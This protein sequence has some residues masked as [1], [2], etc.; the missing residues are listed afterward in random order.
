VSCVCS[1]PDLQFVTCPI[2]VQLKNERAMQR[3]KQ[4]E[5]FSIEYE[6]RNATNQII[7]AQ[8]SLVSEHTEFLVAGELQSQIQLMPAVSEDDCYTLRYTLFP[9]K[10]GRLFLPKLRIGDRNTAKVNQVWLIKDFT[11]KCYVTNN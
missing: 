9:Q 10:L 4:Y 1:F 6:I 3:I 8:C 7:D 5:P 2:N 11:R